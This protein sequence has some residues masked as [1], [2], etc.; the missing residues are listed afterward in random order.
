M[1]GF[2]QIVEFTTAN[3][4][5]IQ[6]RVQEVRE[7]LDGSVV[8]SAVTADVDRP[9]TYV[10]II[11]FSSE[12]AAEACASPPGAAAFVA[13]IAEMCDQPPTTRN[14]EPLESWQAS[15]Y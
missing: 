12:E 1:T 9:G 10:H 7:G 6:D 15:A 8:R 5:E 4:D 3:I 13:A 2:L 14:L 11:E